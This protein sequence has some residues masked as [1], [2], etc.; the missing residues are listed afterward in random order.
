MVKVAVGDLSCAEGI[1]RMRK[2]M[3]L[4]ASGESGE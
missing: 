3:R 2:R 1:E 4:I